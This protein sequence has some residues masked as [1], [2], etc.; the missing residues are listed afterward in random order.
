MPKF[1][2]TWINIGS[3][4]SDFIDIDLS[5]YLPSNAVGVILTALNTNPS[6]IR[7]FGY[8]K[9][10][11][12]D[13]KPSPE[14]AIYS[15][16]KTSIYVGCDENQIIEFYSSGAVDYYLTGYFTDLEAYFFTNK[17]DISAEAY[18]D[19]G[20]Y[21]DYSVT[22]DVGGDDVVG[23]LYEMVNTIGGSASGALSIR[24]KGS[25]QD[26]GML[27]GHFGGIVGV[28]VDNTLQ[29]KVTSAKCYMLGYIRMGMTFNDT[30]PIVDIAPSATPTTYQNLNQISNLNANAGIYHL[31]ASSSSYF[32]NL[33]E[34]GT[35]NE[36][37]KNQNRSGIYSVE[38]VNGYAEAKISNANITIY[39]LGYFEPIVVNVEA[40]C[41]TINISALE[42]T[43]VNI[44][45]EA[46]TGVID[47]QGI[48]TANAD[49]NV[50][51]PTGTINISGGRILTVFDDL[52]LY[53]YITLHNYQNDKLCDIKSRNIKIDG[54]AYGIKFKQ[55]IN[56]IDSL[57]FSLPFKVKNPETGLLEYNWRIDYV[58]PE[59]KVF[60]AH[61]DYA[62]YFIIKKV[63]EQRSSDGKVSM[64]VECGHVAS[65]LQ[66]RGV[67]KSI[68]TDDTADVLLD[69]IL[70]NSGWSAGT[71]D[72]FY[73]DSVEK[74]RNFV[75]SN[76]NCLDMLFDLA[77]LFE[78]YLKFDGVNR[79]V[80]FMNEIGENNGVVFRYSK[81]LKDITREYS[82]DDL[83]TRLWAV[84]NNDATQSIVLSNVTDN[85]EPYIDNFSYYETLMTAQQ[86]QDIEDFNTAIL[87]VNNNIVSTQTNIVDTT[88]FLTTDT[89]TMNEKII[90]RTVTAEDKNT[91][92]A[93]ITIEKD[94][95]TKAAMQAQSLLFANEIG[96][97]DGEIIVLNNNISTYNSTL[98][99]YN[100]NLLGYNTTRDNYINSLRTSVGDFIR[101]GV[102]TDASYITSQSLLDD[103]EDILLKNCVPKVTYTMNIIDLSNFTGY[104]IEKFKLGDIVRIIDEPLRLGV[105]SIVTGR[106]TEIE[107]DLINLEKTTVVIAN[108]IGVF[109]D[110]WKRISK[111][112]EL[113][114]QRSQFYE[115]AYTG[116]NG[117]GTPR[118][119]ILQQAFDNNKYDIVTGTSNKVTW[120]TNGIDIEDLTNANRKVRINAGGI[121]ITTDGGDTWKVATSADG[122]NALHIV[123]GTLDTKNINIYN[124][125]Y[126]T[127]HWDS[128]GMYALDPTDEN[129]WIKFNKD[130]LY[131]TEDNGVTFLVVLDFD[132]LNVKTVNGSEAVISRDGMVQT[133]GDSI[134]DNVDATHKLRLDFYIPLEMIS[135]RQLNLNFRLLP[136]RA[137][138]TGAASGAIV[139]T[140]IAATPVSVTIET[141]VATV[142]VVDD[143]STTWT[144]Y[145]PGGGLLPDFMNYSGSHQHIM[146]TDGYHNHGISVGTYLLVDGGGS[147]EFT[148]SGH[149]HTT[150]T[151]LDHAHSMYSVRHQHGITINEHSHNVDVPDHSHAITVP[152]HTH[153]IDYGIFEDTTATQVKVYVDGVLRMDNGG[154]GY[155]TDQ[156]NLNIA[157]WITTSGWHYIELSS[158]RLGR[159]SAA[160][161]MQLFLGV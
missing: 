62:D 119:D 50:Q 66:K 10:G 143:G 81:N 42:I 5:A 63:T 14:A 75:K 64:N 113:V 125:D 52:S 150:T 23:I 57:S 76:S 132:G 13:A 65:L 40:P 133:W 117:D 45:V 82:T 103:A 39:E 121:Y 79:L 94:P 71:V 25:T 105:D 147:V 67:D 16:C 19:Q 38:L 91:L 89:T 61:Q 107:R 73:K 34:I 24:K 56:G 102:F 1:F 141:E 84:G 146:A 85:G 2:D 98:I 120:G 15:N 53:S 28:N 41:P 139:G 33:R 140:T 156:S 115:R 58:L 136:F 69:L 123:A 72:T 18:A 110:M 86:L 55:N 22:S 35:S 108:F 87:P 70:D 137:Y 36:I 114:K 161:F 88:S 3:G 126:P 46:P 20:V 130:G 152:D 144:L 54:E 134:V 118:N 151:E 97:L 12:T 51:P 27:S 95:I 158:S 155:T 43:E 142:D 131:Y 106:I 59:Y 83:V 116:L 128:T 104:D 122:I 29:I 124:S 127:F 148:P 7:Y 109:E 149:S 157:T 159:I 48:I 111:N 135:I 4:G 21:K 153:D 74:V 31:Y 145:P 68:D 60:L 154:V 47:I 26:I 9:N 96:V 160:Y 44:S 11:S 17:I 138:E 101:E 129:K 8:R 99:T 77:E 92:D 112:A 78:G 93:A 49:I 80:D 37:Y 90:D 6:A 32:S 30:A 100:S